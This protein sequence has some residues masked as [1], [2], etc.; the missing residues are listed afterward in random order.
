MKQTNS[1]QKK[2]ASKRV[3]EWM[4]EAKIL[5]SECS[6]SE[7]AGHGSQNTIVILTILFDVFQGSKNSLMRKRSSSNKRLPFMKSR[8]DESSEGDSNSLANENDQ[9]RFIEL[10]APPPPMAKIFTPTFID[11]DSKQ[12]KWVCLASDLV[13]WP[14]STHSWLF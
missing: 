5:R 14:P 13:Q 12:F 9:V 10:P 2:L 11:F 1:T 4:L 6:P 8:E 3:L 7:L